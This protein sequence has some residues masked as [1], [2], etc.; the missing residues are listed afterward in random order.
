MNNILRKLNG[1]MWSWVYVHNV[2]IYRGYTGRKT[3]RGLLEELGWF[4]DWAPLKSA[5]EPSEH[6]KALIACFLVVSKC[7]NSWIMFQ[8]KIYE[9]L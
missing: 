9:A 8:N 7:S 3:E 6:Y 2:E 5:T 4:Y 1:T